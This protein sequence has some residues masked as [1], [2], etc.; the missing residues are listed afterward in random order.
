MSGRYLESHML[1]T[2]TKAPRQAGQQAGSSTNTATPPG[3]GP[4]VGRES[5]GLQQRPSDASQESRQFK[6]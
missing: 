1:R 4:V 3:L 2:V 5:P 6:K